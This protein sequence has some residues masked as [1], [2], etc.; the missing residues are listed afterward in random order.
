M[1]HSFLMSDNEKRNQLPNSKEYVFDLNWFEVSDLSKELGVPF[2]I[3]SVRERWHFEDVLGY[4]IKLPTGLLVVDLGMGLASRKKLIGHFFPQESN[5]SVLLTHSDWDHIGNIDDFADTEVL[6]HTLGLPRLIKGWS[7]REM[8]LQQG[9]FTNPHLQPDLQKLSKFSIPSF[10]RARTFRDG[11]IIERFGLKIEV[12][13][14]PGHTADSTVFFLP[15]LGLLIT[16]DVIYPAT[17]DLSP[18]ANPTQWLNSLR[19]IQERVGSKVRA[20]LPGHNAPLAKPDLLTRHIRAFEGSL[21]PISVDRNKEGT[22]WVKNF[23][24]FSF[25]VPVSRMG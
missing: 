5:I 19:Y 17:H 3:L 20:I 21:K 22:H 24:D 14:A 1:L 18:P 16:G 15:Q 23:G 10:L 11:Q 25:F 2:P 6:I 4:F 7:A 13:H 12:I 9:Q 8:G